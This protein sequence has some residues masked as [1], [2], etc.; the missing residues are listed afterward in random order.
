M[1]ARPLLAWASDHHAFPLPP[2]HPFPLA[3]YALVRERLLAE[4]VLE[5]GWLA[6]SEPAP[7]AWLRSAHDAEY[8]ARTLAG[9][10]SD[11][12]VRRLGL[13]WSAALVTRARAA[14]AG[15]V[16]AARAA[17]VHGVSGNLAGGTHHAF[18][19]RGEAYCLFNDVAVAVALLRR[20]GLATRAFVLDLDVHQGNG[21][22]AC[23][24]GDPGVFTFSLHARHNYPLH[25][26][27][28]TLDVEL[29]DGAGDDE[30]LRALDRHVPAA[31]AAHAPD[32]VFY[33]AG[34]DALHTDRLGRLR[35][36]H[37]G[38][39][40]RDRRVFGWFEQLNLPVCVTLGGG[41]GR[42]LESTV[43]AHVNVWRA[44]RAARER[45]PAV[46]RADPAP[47]ARLER[48]RA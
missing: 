3:K 8:V 45:R 20:D 47:P 38:L 36:T 43:E 40:E 21:T 23:F 25:K 31:L 35:M 4:R 39:A 14:L 34:V 12:E 2:A 18:P 22:A 17:L 24:A 15:T 13:P 46:A 6:R 16:A 10:W 32:L 37:A 5:P 48:D 33:Q 30:A 7:E 19:D 44:A 41:Y 27:R 28:S 11:A 42:P 9:G 29:D 26:L 1:S